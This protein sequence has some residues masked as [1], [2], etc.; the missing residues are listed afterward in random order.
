MK[1]IIYIHIPKCGGSTVRTYFGPPN[2]GNEIVRIYGDGPF[3]NTSYTISRFKKEF[4][5]GL[6]NGQKAIGH[7]TYDELV[8]VLKNTSEDVEIYTCVRNPID[9]VISLI[10]YIKTKNRLVH[11]N[12]ENMFEYIKNHLQKRGE[13]FQC[14]FLGLPRHHVDVKSITDSIHVYK[15]ENQFELIKQVNPAIQVE[16]I[17]PCNV[18]RQRKVSNKPNY[19]NIDMLKVDEQSQLLEICKLDY[20]LYMKAK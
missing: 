14:D 20:D 13:N 5:T 2:P 9:R 7:I 3:N 16:K 17:E 15:M 8:P 11:I 12:Q 10:N 1:N 18:T 6:T 19:I 4:P